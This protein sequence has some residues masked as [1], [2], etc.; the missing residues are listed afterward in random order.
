MI[1]KKVLKY[2]FCLACNKHDLRDILNVFKFSHYL[3]E[4]LNS[5]NPNRDIDQDNHNGNIFFKLC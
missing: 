2:Y 4:D 5:R 3:E 1:K